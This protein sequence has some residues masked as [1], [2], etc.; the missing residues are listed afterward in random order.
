MQPSP[1]RQPTLGV[2]LAGRYRILEKIGAGTIGEVCRALDETTQTSVVIKFLRTGPTRDL[3]QASRLFEGAW[4]ASLLRHPH[5]VQVHETGLSEFGPFVVMEDLRGEHV[6]RIL[7]RQGRLKRESCF[8]II[9]PVLSALAATH[10]IGLLHGDV[11]PE[12]VILCQT[13]D[14]RLN[15]KLLD[16]GAVASMTGVG[17]SVGI[18]E[19]LAP[20]QVERKPVDHRADLF[21]VCVLLYELLSNSL[22]FHGSTPAATAYR[23]VS[24]PCPTLG[25]IGLADADGLSEVVM[26]GLEKEPSRRYSNARDLLDA[27]RPHMQGSTPANVLL[28]ELLPLATL[29]RQDS[30][31]LPVSAI[32]SQRPRSLSSPSP[33][34]GARLASVAARGSLFP[35]A[36]ARTETPHATRPSDRDGL[37]PVL[38]AR[39]R[40]RYHVRAIIWQALDDYVRARRP[41]EMRERILY[42]VGN[43]DA[44]DLLIGTLQ[45]IVYCE[46][47][48]M[49]QYIELATARLF[50]G[51]PA[52]CRAAGRETVDG[53]LAAA[54]TRSIPP[55][56]TMAVTLRRTCRILAPLFDFGD[57]QIDELAEGTGATATISGIDAVCHGLRLWIVGLVERSLE[58][59]H[60]GTI[61]SV[62]RGETSFMPRLV[63]EVSKS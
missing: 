55:S 26:R 27:L 11:K 9:E 29:A 8:A 28:S 16:F 24:M 61:L 58:I 50:S 17:Q 13:S 6:G 43:D 39:Y 48:S 49:S 34:S 3:E 15:V 57:W 30:G 20:E 60:H 52:W 32:A 44:G 5:I 12:N 38:P 59:S 62:T 19:Y 45:G 22:P 10:S 1:V 33:E 18:T 40:G 25:Q 23:I 36:V 63:I 51:D 53:V 46:L 21:S 54:L 14:S 42:D 35:P 31:T 56:P 2:V 41:A 4:T 37:Q 47:D 7:E